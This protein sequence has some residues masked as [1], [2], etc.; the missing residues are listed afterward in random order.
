M[1]VAL[2]VMKRRLEALTGAHGDIE[3]EFM[4]AAACRIAACQQRMASRAETR[5]RAGHPPEEFGKRR[6]RQRF[7]GVG[8]QRAPPVL[9]VVQPP[10]G[11]GYSRHLDHGQGDAGARHRGLDRGGL[12]DLAFQPVQATARLVAIEPALLVHQEIVKLP[13]GP[14][15]ALLE[16]CRLEEAHPPKRRGKI[17]GSGGARLF[18]RTRE[19]RQSARLEHEARPRETQFDDHAH[20]I[21]TQVSEAAEAERL[22]GRRVFARPVAR[23]QRGRAGQRSL[24]VDDVPYQQTRPRESF[25]VVARDPGRPA[26][27]RETFEGGAICQRNDR[28]RVLPR[29]AAK[30]SGSS[31]S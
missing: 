19:R 11:R 8:A 6:Q 22:F 25:G 14:G 16:A 29:S 17:V 23:R 4:D 1:A 15:V 5:S 26:D 20:A 7:V 24:C 12:G 3:L 10:A 27:S 9:D 2:V 13:A 18:Q 31:S 21:G 30:R 28:I